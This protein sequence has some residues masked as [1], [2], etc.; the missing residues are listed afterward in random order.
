MKSLPISTS[1]NMTLLRQP[2]HCEINILL[3]SNAEAVKS[4]SLVQ[5]NPVKEPDGSSQQDLIISLKIQASYAS[6]SKLIYL[7]LKQISITFLVYLD[8]TGRFFWAPYTQ[9]SR[10][11]NA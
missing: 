5:A 8:A 6:I 2:L 11:K 9:I 3:S 7:I 1:R 4:Y 10:R